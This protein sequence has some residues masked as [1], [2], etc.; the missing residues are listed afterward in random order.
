MRGVFKKRT[1]EELR[2]PEPTLFL[3]VCLFLRK[4]NH[5]YLFASFAYEMQI[6]ISANASFLFGGGDTVHSQTLANL[7]RFADLN[8]YYYYSRCEAA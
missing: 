7:K 8:N 2:N 4:K 3:F 5:S 1:L 6:N